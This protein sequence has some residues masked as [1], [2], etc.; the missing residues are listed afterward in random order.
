MPQIIK[1]NLTAE[2]I[3]GEEILKLFNS[4]TEYRKL[5]LG[6]LG[7]NVE[8]RINYFQQGDRSGGRKG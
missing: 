7:E 3:G 5:K 6:P 2:E 8:D 4:F 1:D